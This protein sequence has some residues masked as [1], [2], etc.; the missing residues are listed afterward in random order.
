M[1]SPPLDLEPRPDFSDRV[2]A[3]LQASADGAALVRGTAELGQTETLQFFLLDGLL[4]AVE[5]ANG[6]VAADEAACMWL[7]GLRWYRAATGAFPT[8]SPEPLPRWIDQELA[9]SGRPWAPGDPQ[10]LAGLSAPQ[11]ASTGRPAFPAADGP[12]VLPRAAAMA[13][14]PRVDHATTARLAADAAALTHGAPA[15]HRAAGIAARAIRAGLEHGAEA[16]G[17][18]SELLEEIDDGPYAVDG[19]DGGALAAL[20]SAL[21]AAGAEVDSRRSAGS[22][23][24]PCAADGGTEAQD[25]TAVVHRLGAA[26]DPATAA[27]AAALV[28]SACGHRRADT[29]P[30]PAADALIAELHRRWIEAV[31]GTAP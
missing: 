21:A 14:L 31:L 8:G 23:A 20:R 15:A 19:N 4:E 6:G 7:A 27:Y 28:A 3:V 5:W 22:G 12:G 17:R 13:L 2:L 18:W 9:S 26:P 24:R 29:A 16:T 10:D 11:M 25:A 1:T 30:A